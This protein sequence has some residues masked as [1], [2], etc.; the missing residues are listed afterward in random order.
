VKYKK[1]L[2]IFILKFVYSAYSAQVIINK[3][4]FLTGKLLYT[5]TEIAAVTLAIGRSSI[6]V[7]PT[8]AI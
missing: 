8:P 6:H 2:N 1:V 3:T 4:I 5:V 7:C